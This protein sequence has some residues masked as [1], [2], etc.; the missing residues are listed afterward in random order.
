VA[1]HI[2]FD[3]REDSAPPR[4]V[5][6]AQA[7]FHDPRSGRSDPPDE[8]APGSGEHRRETMARTGA[9]GPHR[10]LEEPRPHS[11]PS[12]CRGGCKL[13]LGPRQEAL[14][15]LPGAAQGAQRR[16]F[17]RPLARMH[18]LVPRAKRGAA[19]VPGAVPIH[20]GRRIS[21]HQRGA[22]SVAAF[23][24]AEHGRALSARSIT[25]SPPAGRGWRAKRAG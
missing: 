19:A 14:C 5:G 13:C 20:P 21:G 2:S 15:R 7:G 25:L 1:R 11:R 12:S 18:P 8:A 24:G 3:R 10:Q 17:R 23:A 22:V 16:R 9:G 4:R 6:G